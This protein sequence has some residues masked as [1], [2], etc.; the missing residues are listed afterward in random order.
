MAKEGVAV[1]VVPF[2]AQGHLNQLLHFSLNLSSRSHR[3][4]LLSVHYACSASHVRQAKSRIH[5]WDDSSAGRVHFHELPIPPFAAPPPDPDADAKFPLHALPAWEAAMQAEAPLASLL[6]SL[7]SSSRR[8]VVVYDPLM[9]FAGHAADSIPNAESYMLRCAP[10]FFSLSLWWKEAL[11]P[12]EPTQRAIDIL[13]RPL[14]DCFPT[15]FWEFVSRNSFEVRSHAGDLVNTCRGIEAEFL[16][17]LAG[18]PCLRGKKLFAVGPLC[19][20]AV[21]RSGGTGGGAPRRHEC[22]EWLDKQPPASVVYV[23]FG[24]TTSI[25]DEQVR[26]LAL[27]LRRSGQRFVW[28]LRDADRGD[29]FADDDGGKARRREL[30]T[31]FEEEVEGVGVVLRGWAP[32]LEILAHPST[33]AFVSHC[34][35]NSCMESMSMGVPIIAWPMHSDQPRNAIMAKSYLKVGVTVRDWDDRDRVVSAAEIED[36]IEKV[37]VLDEGKEVRKRAKALGEAIRLAVSDGG[38]SRTDMDL[39]IAR[40]TR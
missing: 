16:D 4:G 14:E 10:A 19:P 35:W 37:M 32:Q 33:G 31:G 36:A 21:V 29:V 5:G 26:E 27:G 30:P 11:N 17:L 39:F 28:V 40:I 25:S 24:S 3:H 22:L 23:S 7:S 12:V 15:E 9:T 38:S 8:L 20:T 13:R 2:P 18:E 34:G 1:V 6:G